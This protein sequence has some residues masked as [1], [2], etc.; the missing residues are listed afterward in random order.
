MSE[1]DSDHDRAVELRAQIRAHNEAYHGRDVPTVPDSTYDELLRQLEEI[2]TRRPDLTTADSP[3]RSVGNAPSE[4]FS[5]VEH[6]VPMMSLDNAMNLDEL[7][8]WHERIIKSFGENET[9]GFVCELKFD[10]LAVSLR[11]ENGDLVQAATRGNGRIGEDVTLNVKTINDIPHRLENAPA[12]LEVRGEVYLSI[13]R[14]EELNTEQIDKGDPTYAN[15]RNTAAGSLRQKDP[16]VTAARQLSF[17]C[18]QLGEVVGGPELQSSEQTFELLERLGLPVNPEVE[19]FSDFTEVWRFCESW[20]VNRHTPDYEIDGVVVK[21]ADLAQ[22]EILG[23]TSR[24]PRWAIAFKFPPEET[25]TRLT[26][27]RVSIGR[28]GRAT[29]FAVL[30]PVFVGGSTVGMATLHNEDQVSAKD[31]RPGDT[32]IVRK[33]GDVIPE[34]VGPVLAERPTASM[35]WVFPTVCPSCEENLERSEGDA[36][37]YCINRRC[38]ARIETGIS[39]F[40]SRNALDIEGLGERTVGLLVEEGLVEDAGDLF[41]LTKE[42]LLTVLVSDVTN[43]T[44]V[45]NLL[46]AIDQARECLLPN[47]LIGLGVEHLGPST[48]EL[49]ARRFGDIETISTAEITEIAAIDGIGP[50]IAQSVKDF[51]SD[52]HH[53]AVVDKLRTNGVRLDLVEGEVDLPQ[54]LAGR[55]VVVT[56]SLDGWF[57]AR[58]EAKQAIVAR[59][60]KSPGSVSKS[61]YALVVG[62]DA[63][64]TKLDKATDLGVPTLGEAGLRQLLATGQLP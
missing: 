43:E 5:A 2:E 51:F 20:M 64:Q 31:V 35:Q 9:Y 30:E 40:A 8:A 22:R 63:G 52:A 53:R 26:A 13:S 4:L 32:V 48:A 44:L 25:T 36:N 11:Y 37:T 10:G 19:E 38:P 23:S 24:A 54:I 50:V 58:D 17:W 49:L 56:G 47:L 12:V 21:V 27:I 1:S 57:T 6:R 60:G 28:T 15:P 42:Q 46:T 14:F 3:T 18:Y 61:T 59:G 41:A 39:H 33:A 16:S 45:N 34:V 62:A 55:S 7:N 29:P